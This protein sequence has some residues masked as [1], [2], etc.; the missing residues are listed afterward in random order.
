[1]RILVAV[2][3]LAA[4]RGGTAKKHDAGHAPASA[5]SG[6]A[7]LPKLP[8]SPDGV[9]EVK[10]LEAELHLAQYPNVAM[11]LSIALAKIRGRVEDYQDTLVR[12]QAWLAAKPDDGDAIRT[13]VQVL[14]GVHKFAEARALLEKVPADQRAGLDVALDE[15]T[16]H[17]E[18]SAR[19]LEASAKAYPTTKNL[20]GYA[21]ILGLQGKIDEALAVMPRAAA[22]LHDNAPELISWMLFQ[23]GRLYELDGKPAQARPFFEE[24]HRRLPGSL[25][26]TVHL[27][28]AMIATGEDTQAH[29]LVEAA[30]VDNRHPELLAFDHPV[31]AQREWERYVAAL[32]EAFSDHAARFYLTHDP[33]RALVLARANLANRDTAEARAL[34]AEAALAAGDAASACAVVEP[35]IH[36]P[37]ARAQRFVA[38]R[39]LAKCGRTEDADRL[40]HDLGITR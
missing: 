19:A 6:S 27:A 15:A 33:A 39:A 37:A 10:R 12:S 36:G 17:L 29:A 22:A 30:L 13:R 16:G 8:R 25:E 14:T 31:E 35:L 5:I 38:W 40:A 18:S 7:A 24:A 23:W 34:V 28:Q 1:M 3:L 21:A 26:A 9:A 2:A 32:P 4:C 11:P 20:V